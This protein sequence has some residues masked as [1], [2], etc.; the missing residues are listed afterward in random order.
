MNKEQ[1][2]EAEELIES[3]KKSVNFSKKTGSSIYGMELMLLYITNLEQQISQLTNNWNELE[4]YIE[5]II[6]DSKAGSGQQYNY[7]QMLKTM[8]EIKEGNND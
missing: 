2:E 6:I 1:L 4:E 7:L 8:K 5:K 3:L